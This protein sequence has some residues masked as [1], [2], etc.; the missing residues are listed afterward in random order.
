[1]EIIM[2]D[3]IAVTIPKAC[4][5]TGLGR[6]SIYRLFDEGKLKKRKAGKRTLI[7]VADLKTYIESL[8]EQ[9][10]SITGTT[11]AK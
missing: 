1:V 8:T 9:P 2:T 7:L 3:T 10:E 4:S 11:S 6:T 5:M